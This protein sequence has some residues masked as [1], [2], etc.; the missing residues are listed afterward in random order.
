MMK[1][2]QHQE[3]MINIDINPSLLSPLAGLLIVVPSMGCHEILTA[4]YAG[5][6]N[7][8]E[9]VE[10]LRRIRKQGEQMLSSRDCLK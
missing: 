4:L 6:V 5:D 2:G 7:Y 1:I 8:V 3:Q 9:F 10:Q